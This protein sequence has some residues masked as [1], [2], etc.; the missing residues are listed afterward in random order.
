MAPGPTPRPAWGLA[1]ALAALLGA[2]VPAVS[3][4]AAPGAGP[5]SAT[6]LVA[7]MRAG[8]LA[9]DSLVRRYRARISQI[10]AEPGGLHAIL[11]LNPDAVAQA[12]ALA[13]ARRV[14]GTLYGLPIVVKD[15]IETL[16]PLPTTA[17][18][19]ALLG[20]VTH[21]DAPVIARLRMA[22]AIVLGKSNLS[23]WANFRSAHASSGWSAVGGL[24]R[25]PHDRT[26]TACGSSAGSAAAVAAG[27][28]AAAIGTETDGSIT[29]PASVNGIVG[30]KPT[31]GLVSRSRIV[32]I[33]TS[34]DTAGP[35]TRT[36]RDAAL[37]L[38]VMA[39]S[40]HD[41][42]V[43]VG[44]DRH[45]TDYLAGLRPEALRGRR[46]GVMRFAE[47]GNPGVRTL[48]DAALAR[49][50]GAGAILVD[51][52]TFDG[53]AIDG[54]ELTVLLSEFH[55][56]LNAYLAQTPAEV[57]VRDLP[58]L[59][60]FDRAHADREMPWFGQDLFEQAARAPALSDPSYKAARDTARRLAGAGGI[61]AMLAHD[62]LDALVAPT[63]GPAWMT[64]P[65]LGDRPGDGTGA[66]SLAA[67]AGYPHLSVPM[68]RVRGLPVGL[69][70]IGPAWSEA[71][72]LALGY[73]F[74]QAAS[75]SGARAPD[76]AVQ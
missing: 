54:P 32:P 24:T 40:D 26:R 48:F 56:G 71:T 17:G 61:D 25:N 67:V 39:G 33:S 6:D 31:V 68:G 69:S 52:P 65:V 14:R 27:L 11:A 19:L 45:H 10:D 29:C 66:G 74:E 49:L 73:G 23:E 5:D 64:D 37:L 57:T 42:P 13:R 59:I 60:A 15:N 35:M 53:S 63:I 12:A 55:A 46:I 62:R 8:R 50:R 41:D 51:I 16:D 2:S 3:K 72:L 75:T 34:Q 9:P 20:N 43:T 1:C 58:T 18:S 7:A 22:G 21:R 30:L 4:A 28:A 70:F 36:V 76:E 44:A 47:G 38:G